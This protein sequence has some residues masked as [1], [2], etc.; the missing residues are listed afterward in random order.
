MCNL[1]YQTLKSD[2]TTKSSIDVSKRITVTIEPNP[3]KLT[4]EQGESMRKNV[5]SMIRDSIDPMIECDKGWFSVPQKHFNEARVVAMQSC[6]SDYNIYST[7]GLIDLIR[8]A[9]INDI[10]YEVIPL[11]KNIEQR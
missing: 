11:T 5:T 10:D 2:D 1:H 4:K 6:G 8:W 7:P 3:F 9:Y